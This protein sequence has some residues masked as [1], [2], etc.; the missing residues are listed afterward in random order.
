M[1]VDSRPPLPVPGSPS[2]LAAVV[3]IIC[4]RRSTFVDF[5]P[6]GRSIVSSYQNAGVYVFN[7][8]DAASE[9]VCAQEAAYGTPLCAPADASKAGIFPPPLQLNGTSTLSAGSA[10]S[11]SVGAEDAA[12]AST[13]TGS[14]TTSPLLVPLVRW[15]SARQFARCLR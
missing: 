2:C 10:S 15:R 3:A 1:S 6:D 14:S 13:V 9:A 12:S 8:H 11:V 7:L 5:S 4:G